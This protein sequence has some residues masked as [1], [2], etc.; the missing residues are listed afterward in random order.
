MEMCQFCSETDDSAFSFDKHGRGFWCEMCGG[1]TYLNKQENQHK[2][3]MLLETKQRLND[4][5][6]IKNKIHFNK[7]LSPLRY[8]GGKS[9]VINEL[10][11]RLQP[12]KC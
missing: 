6:S 9:K 10:H 1:F 2:F 7:R 11:S 3:T 8:P 12:D 5:S 4:R